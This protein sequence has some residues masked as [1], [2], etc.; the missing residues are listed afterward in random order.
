V[1]RGEI[2]QE[3]KAMTLR[4]WFRPIRCALCREPLPED[5]VRVGRLL[6]CSEQHADKYRFE[7]ALARTRCSLAGSGG[8]G[9]C[10]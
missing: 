7:R 10:K 8:A 4:W 6:I 2:R 1:S 3:E 5:P 9:C